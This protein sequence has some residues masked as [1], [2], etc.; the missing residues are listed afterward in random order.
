[1]EITQFL[2]YERK[3]L[4]SS[5]YYTVAL[6][7]KIFLCIKVKNSFPP[8]VV[9]NCVITEI[10]FLSVTACYSILHFLCSY[11]TFK[12]GYMI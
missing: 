7:L 12:F 4:Q 3:N 6:Q 1:M 11:K 10:F 8:M 9:I 2:S 5:H